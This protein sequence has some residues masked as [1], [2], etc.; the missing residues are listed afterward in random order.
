MV[1][2][3]IRVGDLKTY[4]ELDFNFTDINGV[5]NVLD[6]SGATSKTITFIDPNGNIIGPFALTFVT[7]GTDGKAFYNTSNVTSQWTIAGLWR[8]F[9]TVTLPAGTFSSNDVTRQVLE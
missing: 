2:G 9:G 1:S 8:W 6:I 5:N 4:V 7:N 3:L